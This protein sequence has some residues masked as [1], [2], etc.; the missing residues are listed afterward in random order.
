VRKKSYLVVVTLLLLSLIAASCSSQNNEESYSLAPS[1]VLPEEVLAAPVSVRQAYQFAVANPDI[2]KE[3]PC[4]CG[5]G[6]MGH[7]SN[8]ACYIQDDT[9]PDDLVFDGHAL[10]CS[11]CVDIT[12]DT[13]EMLDSGMS[14]PE[15]RMEIDTVYSA[16][17]PSNMP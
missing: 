11:I 4:Y 16:Y 10:G 1:E 8:Y 13:M 3:I 5:C 12:F 2:L 9:S 7:T 17:G 15:I 14:L 6:A